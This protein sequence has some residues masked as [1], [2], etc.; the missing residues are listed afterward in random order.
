MRRLRFL[1]CGALA[2]A[3]VSCSTPSSGQARWIGTY[4]SSPIGLPTFSKVGPHSIPPVATIAGTIRYR[5]RVSQGG[6]KVRLRVSNTFSAEPLMIKSASVGL[7]ADSLDAV[8]G[9]LKPATFAGKSTITL[10]V[11]ASAITD[12]IILAVPPLAD[13]VV[14]IYA[15]GGISVFAT[16]N[17]SKMNPGFDGGVDAVFLDRWAAERHVQVRPLVSAIEALADHSSGVVVT[18]GDSIT[19]AWVDS[20]TGDRGW[21]GVLSRRLE[22]QGFSVVNAG[23]NSNRLLQSGGFFGPS[24]VA[25]LDR[26]VF[27]VP[28]LSHIVVLEGINDIGMSGKGSWFGDSPLVQPKELMGAYSQIVAQAHQHGV[29]V[30][31]AT[32]MPFAGA[33]YF[34]QERERVRVA[35]NEWIRN[36]R[37]FDGVIDFDAAMRDPDHPASLKAEFDSGDHLHPNAAGYRR[38]GDSIDLR[39]FTR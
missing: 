27:A 39:L 10:P 17:A 18:L 4:Q 6:S 26:D 22:S 20:A 1:L 2:L 35:V 38:M 11:G 21:S 9:S 7:A 19:D 29:K 28:G 5:L 3:W 14:S 24:A 13:L 8:P 37:A 25:R 36:S 16:P 23:I 32:I 33:P 34:S 15:P 30:I 31:G 12:P